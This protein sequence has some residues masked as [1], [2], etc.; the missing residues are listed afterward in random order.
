MCRSA[1]LAGDE[2]AAAGGAVPMGREVLPT[3][4]KP[5]HYDVTLEPDF[6]KFTYGGTVVIE[7]VGV[8]EMISLSFYSLP[9]PYN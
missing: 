1:G 9:L 8:Y 6:E 2:G 5:L 4:V 3:N 7:Y